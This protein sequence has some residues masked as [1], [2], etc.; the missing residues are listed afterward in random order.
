LDLLDELDLFA[1]TELKI[2]GRAT[3]ALNESLTKGLEVIVDYAF[4]DGFINIRSVLKNNN[5]FEIENDI[6]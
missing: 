3:N 4:N 6:A 5:V 1:F 2:N